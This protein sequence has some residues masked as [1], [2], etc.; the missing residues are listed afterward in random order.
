MYV[1]TYIVPTYTRTYLLT[2]EYEMKRR[3]LR[4]CKRM[5]V[6]IHTYMYVRR[7]FEKISKIF[8]D[9]M[10]VRQDRHADIEIIRYERI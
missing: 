7:Y 2:Y 10:Y 3:Y 9:K 4:Y 1:C 5:Y 6:R 8:D